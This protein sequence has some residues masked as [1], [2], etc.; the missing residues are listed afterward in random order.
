MRIVYDSRARAGTREFH[1]SHLVARE[2]VVYWFRMTLQ[3]QVRADMVAAMKAKEELRL[4]VLRG[5]LSLFTQ[6]LTATKRTP[7]DTLTDEEV[8]ALI[9][10]SLKQ[11]RDAA[12]QFRAGARE[13][14]AAQEESEAVLLE[15]YLPAMLGDD[16]IE[17]VVRAKIEAL[18]V[19]DKSG[20]G[21]L[22]G[23]VMGELKGR[24]D[25]AVVKHVVERV[26]G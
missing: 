4:S 14:L 10:R 5:L 20:I 17:A 11:R 7:K 13:D 1:G 15:A 24:A 9:R 6:E 25:G 2:G 23:A 8:L 19:T 21:K 16:E 3:E 26:L 12:A 22:I 18:G